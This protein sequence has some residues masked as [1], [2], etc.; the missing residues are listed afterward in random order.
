MQN[1]LE[2]LSVFGLPN[3]WEFSVFTTYNR[4]KKSTG[5][6]HPLIYFKLKKAILFISVFGVTKN[7]FM[8]SISKFY[9]TTLGLRHSVSL[10]SCWKELTF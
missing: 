1:L 4:I 5:L 6:L 2:P 3:L 7:H 8:F 9:L 10:F